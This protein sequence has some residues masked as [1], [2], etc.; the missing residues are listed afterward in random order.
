MAAEQSECSGAGTSNE[1]LWLESLPE[2]A[3]IAGGSIIG[4]AFASLWTALRIE[5]TIVARS[6]MPQ[7]A[8]KVGLD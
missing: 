8:P 1:A 4:C 6:L 7:K 3:V 5:V 2:S